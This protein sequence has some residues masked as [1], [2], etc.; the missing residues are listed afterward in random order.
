MV[1]DVETP[2]SSLVVTASS[3]NPTLVPDTNILLG[4]NGT[5]RALV[6]TP[7]TNQFGVSTITLSVSDGQANTTT[8]VTLTVNPVN[9]L[10]TIAAI[11]DQT[12]AED[13]PTAPIALT[14]ADL[15]TSAASL[16]LTASSS[17]PALI[18]NFT[19]GG[20]GANRTLVITPAPN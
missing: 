3:S 13:T 1:N 20:S 14:V 15:E 16:S 4:G 6:I 8:F 19:F 11:A 10:P 18:S 7:A 17:N 9:D 2:A 5:N 12:T